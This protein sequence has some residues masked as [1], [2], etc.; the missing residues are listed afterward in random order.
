MSQNLSDN[1]VPILYDEAGNEIDTTKLKLSKTTVTVNAAILGTKKVALNMSA[2]GTPADG[3]ALAGITSSVSNVWIKGA[4]A[5]INPITSIEIPASVLDITGA[6]SSLETTIN[7]TDYLPDGV[8]LLDSSEATVLVVV[9]IEAYETRNFEIPVDNITIEGLAVENE[10]TFSQGAVYVNITG[11]AV[12]LDSLN[13]ETLRGNVDVTELSLGSH[14]VNVE[15]DIDENKFVVAAS[16]TQIVI[17][18]ISDGNDEGD[19]NDAEGN[20]PGG[21]TDEGTPPDVNTPS[22]DTAEGTG[23]GEDGENTDNSSDDDSPDTD[24]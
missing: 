15:V 7:I 23:N 19:G 9:D 20:T 18:V 10:L 17:S 3:Y 14:V 24:E 5:T 8:A 1:V 21:S 2:Q 12:D 6:T 22:D 4:T 11:L 16:R 13:E